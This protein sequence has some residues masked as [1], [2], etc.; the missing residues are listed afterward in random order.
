MTDN[1]VV[2]LNTPQDPLTELIRQGARDLIAQA[3][4]AELQQLLA[5]LSNLLV[6]C[7]EPLSIPFH[8]VTFGSILPDVKNVIAC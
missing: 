3:V 1:T 7:K 6:V 8:D 2:S 5:I 4:E